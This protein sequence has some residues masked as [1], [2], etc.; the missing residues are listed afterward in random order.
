[1]ELLI[2]YILAN[3]ILGVHYVAHRKEYEGRL[4]FVQFIPLAIAAASSIYQGIK[5]AKQKREAAR[6][7]ADAD[8]QEK[9]NLL[10]ARRMALVGMPEAEYQKQL[11]NIYR[12]QSV[13]LG[14]LR[15]RR[16][17]LAG[18]TSIQQATNDATA[19]L[20]AEDAR[21]RRQAEQTALG[22]ANRSATLKGQEAAYQREY[23]QALSGAAMQNF[24][25]AAGAGAQMMGGSG[26]NN[27]G[28]SNNFMSGMKPLDSSLYGKGGYKG[29]LGL[30]YSKPY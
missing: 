19:N 16:S 4:N 27:I 7:Q 11:Q 13:A 23:G 20:A 18:A 25:N 2:I 22:Q 29:G 3:I 5:G 26:S 15:D 21:M 30:N 17:A 1:M 14:A 6:L 9:E 12:N 10:Q 24:F 28:Q 8:R